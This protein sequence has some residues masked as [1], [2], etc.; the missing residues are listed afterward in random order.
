MYKQ[1]LV[2]LDGSAFAEAALPLATALSRK[3][4]ADL[5]VTTVVEPIPAFAYEEWESAA[6]DW[7]EEYL[8]SV[9]GRISEAAGGKVTT[10]LHTGHV[11]ETLIEEAEATNADVVVMATHGRGTLSRAWLGS[12]AD[13]FMRQAELPVIFVRPEEGD[14][15]PPEP[16]PDFETILVPLDGSELSESAL[17]H[18]PSA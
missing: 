16:R 4:K 2:P 13:G 1:I 8:A 14:A 6:K 7:S 9:A 10:A 12:V 17:A 5:H 3:T 18:P 15:P 11:V